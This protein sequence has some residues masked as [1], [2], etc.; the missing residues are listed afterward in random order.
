MEFGV[1]VNLYGI[2]A[3]IA[4]YRENLKDAFSTSKQVI[5]F[6]WTRHKDLNI[7]TKPEYINGEIVYDD[8]KIAESY[9]D[10]IFISYDSPS[11][12]NRIKKWGVEYTLDFGMIPA[13]RTSLI[14]TGAYRYEKRTDQS[15]LM[16]DK[17]TT[18]YAY[19]G[20]Y[21]GTDNGVDNGRTAQRFNTNFQ[22]IT[23]IPKLRFIISLTTQCVWVDN[24]KR[25]FSYNGKNMIYM[26]DEAGNIVPGNPNKDSQHNK[27]INPTHYMDLAGNVYEFT[28]AHAKMPEF[29]NLI[30]SSKPKFLL[31]DNLDPYFMMNLHLTKEIGKKTTFSFYV[32]NLTN[33]SP[34]RYF[35]ST[36]QHQ[37]MNSDISFGAELKLKF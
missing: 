28:D 21:A 12:G 29:Q 17:S 33:S 7:V 30:L 32:N 31:Q 14:A 4:Y 6:H 10:S 1:D 24:S 23:H 9:Q 5:P 20:I 11:N 16:R 35:R 8:G 34:K 36:G 2:R 26:K 19:A 22:I 37:K 15:P 13:I 18:S 25:T 27:Y 3:N